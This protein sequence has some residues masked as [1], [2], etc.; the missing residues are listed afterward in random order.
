MHERTRNTL[1]CLRQFG[2]IVDRALDLFLQK[3]LAGP[4]AHVVFAA[5]ARQP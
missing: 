1:I 3:T 4:M 2:V 5:T